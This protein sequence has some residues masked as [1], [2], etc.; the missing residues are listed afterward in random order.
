MLTALTLGRRFAFLTVNER[1]IPIIESIIRLYGLESRAIT[2]RP[3]RCFEMTFEGLARCMV[4]NDDEF[5]R[6]I[7]KTALECVHDGA[8]VVIVGGQ[9]FGPAIQKHSFFTLPNTGVPLI[10][11][12][13]CGL[14]MA[15]TMVELER[16]VGL[17]K[18]EHIHSPFKTPPQDVVRQALNTF[19]F[20]QS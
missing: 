12:S 3:V 13:A 17:R 4:D 19:G 15:Q 10:E 16:R 8:D 1:Y 7:E 14:K 6:G 18:S 20:R 9:L 5:I 11:V 2:R